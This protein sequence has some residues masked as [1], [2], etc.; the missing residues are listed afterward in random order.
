MRI[1]TPKIMNKIKLMIKKIAQLIL[2]QFQKKEINQKM[3]PKAISIQ[4]LT[5]KRRNLI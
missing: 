1:Q 2:N 4:I 3:T 5:L